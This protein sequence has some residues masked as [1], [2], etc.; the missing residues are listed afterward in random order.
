MKQVI[1]KLVNNGVLDEQKA[2]RMIRLTPGEAYS[3]ARQRY[4]NELAMWEDKIAR[5]VDLM[6]RLDTSGAEIAATV[7]FVA[8]GLTRIHERQPSES[9]ILTEVKRWKARRRPALRDD[10]IAVAVRAMNA[11]GWISAGMS[12]DL[13]GAVDAVA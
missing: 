4:G 6:L 13:P 9:E 8:Q 3:D 2:G 12:D 1:S 10:D 5:V 7:H 11:L